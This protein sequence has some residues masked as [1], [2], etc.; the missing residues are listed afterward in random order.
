MHQDTAVRVLDEEEVP[1]IEN[2]LR[3]ADLAARGEAFEHLLA[4][5]IDR[6]PELPPH[7]REEG[8]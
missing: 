3:A 7:L 2:A 8:A 4:D 1:L 5:L 6:T